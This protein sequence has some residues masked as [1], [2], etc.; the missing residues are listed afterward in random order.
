MCKE[1]NTHLFPIVSSASDSESV[2]V[3][4]GSSISGSSS[5]SDGVGGSDVYE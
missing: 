1:H 3:D 2:L 4:D 5:S